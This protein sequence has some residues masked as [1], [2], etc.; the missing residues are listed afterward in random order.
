M[1]QEQRLTRREELVGS[2]VQ[3]MSRVRTSIHVRTNGISQAH[4][5]SAQRPRSAA[6]AEAACAA[7]GNL[8]ESADANR[9]A[10]SLLDHDGFPSLS[11]LACAVAAVPTDVSIRPARIMSQNKTMPGSAMKNVNT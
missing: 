4:H 11:L 1:T 2:K 7:V 3:R 6:D 9:H 8:I 5:E 10:D